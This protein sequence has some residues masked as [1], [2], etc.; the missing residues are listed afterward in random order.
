VNEAFQTFENWALS[1]KRYPQFFEGFASKIDKAM[2]LF[3]AGYA[4]PLSERDGQGRRVVLCQSWRL[5]L[6]QFTT[7]DA[8]RL[9]LH[10]VSILMLEEETQISGMVFILNH[11]DNVNINQFFSPADLKDYMDFMRKASTVRVRQ[12]HLVNLPSIMGILVE[13]AKGFLSEKLKKR[14]NTVKNS[15]AVKNFVDLA[16]LPKEYGGTR[17]EIEMMQ[18]FMRLREKYEKIFSQVYHD[19]DQINWNKVSKEKIWSNNAEMEEGVGSFR[20]LEID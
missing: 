10:I 15:D 16:I 11:A 17:A 4:Y 7:Q 3:E 8:I 5:N 1:V 12:V 20:K 18:D 6:N 9:I 19:L 14:L 2:E 13:I